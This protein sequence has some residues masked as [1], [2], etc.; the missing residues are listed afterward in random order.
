[1]KEAPRGLREKGSGLELG[2]GEGPRG[3]AGDERR[4]VGAVLAQ[5]REAGLVPSQRGPA[6]GDQGGEG[7][8]AQARVRAPGE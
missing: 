4:R 5:A 1:M 3:G 8:P 6:L 2:F 7:Q